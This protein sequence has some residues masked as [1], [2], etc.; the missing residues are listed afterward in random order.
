MRLKQAPSF[1][2]QKWG[3]NWYPIGPI[4]SRRNQVRIP[5]ETTSSWELVP[6]GAHPATPSPIHQFLAFPLHI[7]RSIQLFPVLGACPLPSAP[8]GGP[9]SCRLVPSRDEGTWSRSRPARDEGTSLSAARDKGARSCSVWDEGTRPSPVQ[10][11]GMRP[12]SVRDEGVR[13][14]SAQDEGQ[15]TPPVQDK[16]TRPRSS[17]DEGARLAPARDEGA[18]G[19]RA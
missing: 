9:P 1:C 8:L 11:E 10:D 18:H 13:P 17:L 14:R 16:G 12:R 7:C 6:T 3:P 4:T 2:L 19:T 15:R 5:V